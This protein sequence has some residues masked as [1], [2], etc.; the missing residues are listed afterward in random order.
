MNSTT[1][2]LTTTYLGLTLEHPLVPSASPLSYSLERIKRLE[3]AG[4]PAVIMHSLFEEQINQ[5]AGAL[6]HYLNYGSE[7]FA[8]A[9][10]YYPERDDYN[11]G[12]DD[13]LEL[14]RGAKESTNI[15]IIASLNGSSAGGWTRYAK[16]IE[17]AGADALELNIYLIPTDTH[18]TGSDIEKRYFNILRDVKELINIPVAVKLS[19]YFSAM[20][21]MA[22][23]LERAGAD[24]LVLFNRF[25]QPDFDLETRD[26]V[27]HLVLSQPFELTLPLRWVAILYGRVGC[28][29][30][31][32]S[33]V[34]THLDVIK[35][36]MAGAKVAMS[37]SELLQHGL[38]RIR[39]M[40]R[41]LV[42]WMEEN[43]YESIKQMQ[44][45]MSQRFVKDTSAFE[46]ANYMKTLQSWKADPTGASPTHPLRSN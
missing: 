20:A 13:Y 45:S 22:S 1:L 38:A 8:E 25:Y 18:V 19:P 26:V 17:Q 33:G 3:D 30:A 31:I 29:F 34:H 12:P 27:P 35:S 39:S 28:D 11:V 10:S 32:T 14:V 7:S 44:G 43:E 40:K 37:A 42:A 15:P 16:M 23:Q 2:D 24:G 5:Q 46:R 6:D 21:N 36:M 41:A 9:T 4:A